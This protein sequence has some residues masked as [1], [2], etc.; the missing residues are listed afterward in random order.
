MSNPEAKILPLRQ[1]LADPLKP[2]EYMALAR[3]I[4]GTGDAADLDALRVAFLSTYFTG[5]IEPFLVVEGAR[6]GLA[7]RTYYGAFGQFEQELAD[8]ESALYRFDPQVLVLVMRPEDIDPDAVIRYYASEGTRFANLASTLRNRLDECLRFFRARSS[9]PVLVANFSP[10]AELPLGVF[11]ANVANSL[12]YAFEESNRLLRDAVAAHAD[13]LIWDYAGLVRAR[14][15]AEWTD[16]RLWSLSRS[17]VSVKHQP[18]LA[19]HLVRTLCGLLRPPAKCLVLD[20]DNTLWGGVVGDDGLEGIQIGDDYPGVAFKTFQRAVLGL[21]DRGILLAIASKNYQEICEKVFHEHPE[22]LLRW[23]DFAAVRINWEPKSKNLR[24]IAAELNI[25]AG[26][27][28][29]FD[30]NPIE[31]AELRANLPEAAV[32]EVPSDPLYYI[33]ALLDCFSFDA[34]TLTGED[35]TRSELYGQERK[36]QH[37]QSRSSGLEDF[38]KSLEMTSEVGRVGPSTL[39]RVTQLINKTNQ[40]NVTTRRYNSAEIGEMGKSPDHVVAW[41]R[42]RDR[43]GDAG[44]VAVGILRREGDFATID[45][46]LMSCRVMGRK[47]EQAF[48]AYLVEEAR[49]LKCTGLTG[50]YFPTKSNDMVKGLFSDMGF[51]KVKADAT[52]ARYHLDLST[53]SVEWPAI[54]QRVCGRVDVELTVHAS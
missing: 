8:S 53:G 29:L 41:L 13:A 37:L 27:L 5:F 33:P 19:K 36:R 51:D 10:P 22:M 54:I 4:N 49:R 35:I 40:F 50:E 32:I 48:L 6:Q 47:V 9:A 25:G 11:D 31:R 14:G 30:D 21:R 23:D 15:A 42:L 24:E 46:L 43:F 45:T 52:V 16:R 20:L 28:V 7:I 34:V 1:G 18:A 2:A 17:P 38:L 26:A 12:T 39:A 44:L 3:Q